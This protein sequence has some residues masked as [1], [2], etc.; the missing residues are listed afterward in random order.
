MKTTSLT[1]PSDRDRKAEHIELAL[2]PV[3]QSRRSVFDSWVFGHNALPE[4]HPDDVD[5]STT[6]LGKKI[7][8]PL[9][10]SCMTGG[11]DEASRINRNLAIAAEH[12]G[13]ALGVGSQRKALE[14]P[15]QVSTFQVRDLAPHIPLIGNLGAV[16][17]NYGMGI[18]DCEAAVAM[19]QADALA[20]HLNPLQEA[21]QPEGQLNFRGLLPKITHLATKLSVPIIAKEVG[22]GLDRHTGQRLAD[23]GISYL[24]TAG[25]GGTS[26][27]RIEASR[28]RDL[29]LGELFGDWGLTTPESLLELRSIDGVSLIGSG[30]LRSG[31]DA[32]KALAMGAHMV[33]FAQPFLGPALD[34]PEAVV[35]TIEALIRELRISM[36][37][38]GVKR[39]NDLLKTPLRKMSS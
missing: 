6:F 37:C 23:A 20:L 19:I 15:S 36:F 4:I 32:A 22:S 26:W 25:V 28:A 17:L 12:T 29:P 8:A 2:S 27:A 21:I 16:Q 5:L 34:S 9:L 31:L 10:I 14:D 3:S 7:S 33:G 13:V 1:N 18:D 30:G 35:A 38:L 24:D 39:P 11:T